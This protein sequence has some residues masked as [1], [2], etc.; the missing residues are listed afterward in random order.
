MSIEEQILSGLADKKILYFVENHNVLK[1]IDEYKKCLTD[2]ISGE[3]VD[4]YTVYKDIIENFDNNLIDILEETLEKETL[5]IF[6]EYFTKNILKDSLLRD[7][8][9]V[10]IDYVYSRKKILDILEDFSLSQVLE[11]IC[12]EK[13]VIVYNHKVRTISF[14]LLLT[15]LKNKK[16]RPRVMEHFENI[17]K[18]IVTFNIPIIEMTPTVLD[19]RD[20][21]DKY[22]TYNLVLLYQLWNNGVTQDKLKD[23]KID[24]NK[25][26]SQAFFIINKLLT[27]TII[28][29]KEEIKDYVSE[30]SKIKKL[31]ASDISL[32]ERTVL[33][34]RKDTLNTRLKTIYDIVENTNVKE[35]ISKFSG[36]IVY[37]ISNSRFQISEC[38][39][40]I[41]SSLEVFYTEELFDLNEDITKILKNIFLGVYTK[42]P[43]LKINY[44][45]LFYSYIEEIIKY[46]QKTLS[47][48]MF[49]E[50][51]RC[52]AT[53]VK[54]FF[55]MFHDIKTSLNSDEVYSI[56]YPL[57]IM[58]SILNITGYNTNKYRD[59][60]YN[61]IENKEKEQYFKEIV[62]FNLNNFQH[63]TDEI[64]QNLIKI[65]EEEESSTPDLELIKKNRKDINVL[66]IYSNTFASF[67]IKTCNYFPDIIL[68]DEIKTCFLNIILIILNKTTTE[69]VEQFKIKSMKSLD[70]SISKLFV[71]ITKMFQH[72]ISINSNEKKLVKFIGKNDNYTKSSITKMI[73]I[74][75]N[76]DAI[77]TMDY[78]S[79]YYLD[80]QINKLK[81]EL[82]S[83]EDLEPPDELCDPIMSTLIE[84]PIMLPNDIIVD[85]GVITRH[86]LNNDT[87]PFNREHLTIDILKEYNEKP[88]VIAKIDEF[89]VKLSEFNQD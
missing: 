26:L 11:F 42:N 68:C 72:L 81:D 85:Y 79:L 37:W 39:D 4:T 61:A 1:Y 51:D 60:L 54:T 52:I 40:D 76:M 36:Q 38:S 44:L 43:N 84:E 57:Y 6:L 29:Y 82:E 10:L 75:Q 16:A 55:K 78:T 74:L 48:P 53:L 50:Y 32:F 58:T 8:K 35:F 21:K 66:T 12:N 17:T 25:F 3:L 41:L 89:K 45:L 87:N 69:K 18:N 30:I 70:F 77:S 9:L 62:Y 24:S 27:K 20:K 31:L 49:V 67:I 73:T 47:V 71:S 46:N 22:Y 80:I 33:Q 34:N 2:Y 23:I 5:L 56:L 83:L 15:L 14:N 13:N 7:K 64:F 19:E 65:R 63:V 28:G 59:I 88:E 86:L